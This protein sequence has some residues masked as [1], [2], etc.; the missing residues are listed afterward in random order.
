MIKITA[1]KDGDGLCEECLNNIV[2]KSNDLTDEDEIRFMHLLM[3]C[4][5][6]ICTLF[7]IAYLVSL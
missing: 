5:I 7:I 6:A 3:G 1:K 4:F 2:Y